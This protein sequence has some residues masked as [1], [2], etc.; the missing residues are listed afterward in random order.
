MCRNRTEITITTKD[1]EHF[2]TVGRKALASFP[3]RHHV[4][5]YLQGNDSCGRFFES[6]EGPLNFVLG[7]KEIKETGPAGHQALE[8]IFSPE[9]IIL[10]CKTGR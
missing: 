5:F 6:Q 10:I 3:R 2:K 4:L 7:N 1:H 8:L 9:V